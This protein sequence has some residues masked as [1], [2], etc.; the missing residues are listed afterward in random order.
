MTA[1]KALFITGTD[2]EVGKTHVSRGILE[3]A[4]AAGLS[5]LG[6]KPVAAGAIM[7]PEGLRNEDAMALMSAATMPLSFAETN[8]VCLEAAVAPHIAAARE[9]RRISVARLVGV[10]R[11]VLLKRADLT[12]VE[13]AGG[14]RVPLN[15]RELLSDVARELGLPVVLVVG[16]RLGC[17]NHAI[18]T[19]EA[20][21]RDG[22]P[23]AGWIANHV[24]PEMP[25]ARENI[26]TL[27]AMLPAPLLAEVPFDAS[28]C[29][30]H[31]NI[32]ALLTR[33]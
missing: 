12:L 17:L 5:T 29:A 22:L 3:A 15:D 8:P 28:G 21:Q 31:I 11:G 2:T 4:A 16:L 30:A 7:T 19:A 25:V 27:E 1:A 6:L 32:Q 10:C 9:G 14:W 13:G 18:L 20:I 33:L 24:Q 26:A 23:L